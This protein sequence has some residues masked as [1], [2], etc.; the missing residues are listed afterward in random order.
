MDSVLEMEDGQLQDHQHEDG[1]HSHSCSA[2]SS[3][4][5]HRHS[6]KRGNDNSNGGCY[7]CNDYW[8]TDA[9]GDGN[10]ATEYTSYVKVSVTTS[11]SLGSDV[12]ANIGGVENLWDSVCSAGSTLHGRSRRG[13][14]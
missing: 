3:S 6:F 14:I 4:S 12:S 13:G 10:D 7:G 8:V 11:C 1:G 9:M 2:S 5:N